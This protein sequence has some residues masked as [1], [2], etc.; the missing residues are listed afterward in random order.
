MNLTVDNLNYKKQQYQQPAFKAAV[1]KTFPGTETERI[2]QNALVD[3][4]GQDVHHEARTPFFGGWSGRKILGHVFQTVKEH[5][6][7]LRTYTFRND[8][9][10]GV[11]RLFMM[12]DDRDL[13]PVLQALA[14][15]K[16]KDFAWSHDTSELEKFRIEK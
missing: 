15:A 10:Q 13:D 1:L 6:I 2:V 9:E 4:F 16:C 5:Y 7:R 3:V 12:P 8:P 14:N 11:V